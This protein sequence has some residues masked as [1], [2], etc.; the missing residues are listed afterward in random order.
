MNIIGLAGSPRRG[1]NTEILLD[2]SLL[3][4]ASNGATGEKIIVSELNISPCRSCNKCLKTGECVIKDDMQILYRKFMDTDRIIVA[5]PIYFQGVTAQIKALIDRCQALWSRR[6]ILKIPIKDRGIKRIG[7][8][9]FAGGQKNL[10]RNF[11]GAEMTVG[12]FFRV[13]YME[14]NYRLN[15]GGI[16]SKGTIKKHPEAIKQAYDIGVILAK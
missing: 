13:L 1:G 5:S 14:Y 15:F 11:D 9:I 3:G 6:Y 12:S 7:A 8:T 16:D 4:A 2:E 10:L